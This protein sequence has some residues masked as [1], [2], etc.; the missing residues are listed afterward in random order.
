[1]ATRQIVDSTL[2]FRIAFGA[3]S[4][5]TNKR[6]AKKQSY[7]CYITSLYRYIIDIYLFVARKEKKIIILI[8]ILKNLVWEHEYQA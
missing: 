5:L 7:E 4:M 3:S 6:C 8:K 1:M 2:F